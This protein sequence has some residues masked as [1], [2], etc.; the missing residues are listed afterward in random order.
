MCLRPFFNREVKKEEDSRV[1]GTGTDA[2]YTSQ[3]KY[4]KSLMFIKGSDDVDPAVSTL[5][6]KENERPAKKIK[7][8]KAK[9]IEEVAI[10]VYLV[11]FFSVIFFPGGY[12][13]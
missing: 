7:A 12:S 11:Y 3:W 8:E 9:D 6:L 1:S 4:L 5:D 2:V 10:D 13:L